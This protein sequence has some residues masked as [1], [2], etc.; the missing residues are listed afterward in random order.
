MSA[1]RLKDLTGTNKL[2]VFF[3]QKKHFFQGLA[4]FFT[5]VKP[6]I[7]ASLF[8]QKNMSYLFFKGDDFILK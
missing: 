8:A 6:L 4:A 2:E 7:W 5:N 1:Y 3:F